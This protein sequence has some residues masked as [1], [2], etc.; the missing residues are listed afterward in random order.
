MA[1]KKVKQNKKIK[2]I[3]DY[4]HWDTSALIDSD[5]QLKFE[6]LGLKLPDVPPTQ[7]VSIR[8]P[9]QL[10]NELKA[11]GSKEDVPYQALIKHLLAESVAKR[12]KK[13]A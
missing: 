7:V 11:L 8:L 3:E 5:E 1:R 9:S 2:E 10:L 12:K 4:D 13:V 6:D